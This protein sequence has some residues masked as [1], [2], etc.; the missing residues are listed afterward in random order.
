MLEFH[1][2]TIGSIHNSFST[3]KLERLR[4]VFQGRPKNELQ[5]SQ[6]ILQSV[7]V[8]WGEGVV[9]EM[10]H[11]RGKRQAAGKGGFDGGRKEG[12]DDKGNDCGGDSEGEG[13]L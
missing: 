4:A 13:V 5:V 10:W 6:G 8:T 12:L 9:G 1:K 2:E 11:V 3:P 7:P